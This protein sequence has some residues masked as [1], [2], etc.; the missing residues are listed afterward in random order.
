[1]LNINT[2]NLRLWTVEE[3]HQMAEAG[4]FD[5]DE[6]VE[7]LEGKIIY[8]D[9]VGIAHSCAVGRIN[10]LLQKLLQNRSLISVK[11]PIQLD[12]YSEP[13][14]D[15]T[16]VK[17]DLLDYA[18]HH[19]TPDEVY[20]VIEVADTTFKKDCETKG[21][22]YAAAGIINYWVLDVIN[23]QL[24]V[25]RE[26]SENGYKSEVILKEGNSISPLKFSDLNINILEMLPPVIDINK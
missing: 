7:L 9:K 2:I 3:Y 10:Y 5:E 8:R 25:F 20:L 13:E 4:I 12:D 23:R 6:R 22:A 19:P 11:N 15:I 17:I 18:D 21:K 14:P 1:M 16:V 26:P 24:H